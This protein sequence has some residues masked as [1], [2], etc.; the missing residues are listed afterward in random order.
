MIEHLQDSFRRGSPP[1]DKG[2]PG[3]E[4]VGIEARGRCCSWKGM[5]SHRSGRGP[6]LD[7][8]SSSSD[9]N[10]TDVRTHLFLSN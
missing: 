10:T 5:E 4:R 8:E 9:S 6:V 3:R 1:S 7:V 2:D